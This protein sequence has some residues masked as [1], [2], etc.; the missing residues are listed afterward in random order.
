MGTFLM[1]LHLLLLQSKVWSFLSML[2]HHSAGCFYMA[3]GLHV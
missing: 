1:A 2:S 3:G